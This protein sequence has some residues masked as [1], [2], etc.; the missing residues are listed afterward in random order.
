MTKH[1]KILALFFAFSFVLVLTG[2]AQAQAE[3][4]VV[5]PVAVRRSKNLRRSFPM[6]TREKLITCAAKCAKRSS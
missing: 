3:E 4:T 1:S 2:V 5:C 6:S